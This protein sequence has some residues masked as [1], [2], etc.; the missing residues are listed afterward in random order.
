MQSKKQGTLEVRSRCASS[1]SPEIVF[2]LPFLY[3]IFQECTLFWSSSCACHAGGFCVVWVVEPARVGV[4]VAVV[5]VTAVIAS[6][7]EQCETFDQCFGS[8]LNNSI[9]SIKQLFQ[10]SISA[11][12]FFTIKYA[13]TQVPAQERREEEKRFRGFWSCGFRQPSTH[14]CSC[15]RGRR[16]LSRTD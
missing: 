4:C 14:G 13:T 16:L 5:R 3:V 11:V 15:R 10:S 6:E 2:F 12:I 7:L 1:I 8:I 9:I